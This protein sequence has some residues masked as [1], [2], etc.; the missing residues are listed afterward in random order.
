MGRNDYINI[1]R[2]EYDYYLA[3]ANAANFICHNSGTCPVCGNVLELDVI[4]KDNCALENLNL[5][6]IENDIISDSLKKLL[7][8]TE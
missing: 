1:S 2:T 7:T 8:D 6:R 5:F 3:I 4:H